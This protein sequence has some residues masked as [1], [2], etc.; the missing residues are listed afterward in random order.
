DCRLVD[1][2]VKGWDCGRIRAELDRSPEVGGS[3]CAVRRADGRN[4]QGCRRYGVQRQNRWRYDARHGRLV[5][6]M[7]TRASVADYRVRDVQ[8]LRVTEYGTHP[9]L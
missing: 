6:R 5:A 8:P 1:A 3:H 2:R 4:R 7:V 9:A